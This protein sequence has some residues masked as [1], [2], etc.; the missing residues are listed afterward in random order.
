MP[1]QL[2]AAST[3][4]IWSPV[5]NRQSSGQR[6]HAETRRVSAIRAER[7]YSPPGPT[8]LESTRRSCLERVSV[9]TTTRW[10]REFFRFG[11]EES[12]VLRRWVRACRSQF[13][14]FQSTPAARRIMVRDP[15]YGAASRVRLMARYTPQHV[16]SLSPGDQEAP[17]Q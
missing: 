3:P 7:R 16:R 11:S 10:C 2:S 15:H 8:D 14:A 4:V 13:T 9:T 12:S 5:R 1:V 6:R 17:R